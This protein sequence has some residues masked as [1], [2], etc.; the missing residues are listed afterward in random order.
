MIDDVFGP[1][2]ILS[3]QFEGYAPRKGQVDM[4]RAVAAGITGRRHVIAEGPTGTGKSLAYLVPAIDWATRPRENEPSRHEPRRVIVVTGN[5]AL[6]EQLVTKDLPLLQGLLP[7][8]FNFT[9][10]KG[11][12]N[13]L[14]HD[15][16]N[17]YLAGNAAARHEPQMERLLA[18]A[19]ET[20]TGDVSEFPETPAPMLWKQLSVS[21]DQCKGSSCKYHEQCFAEVAKRSMVS[22]NVVVT[23]YHLFFAH[24]LVRAK[25]RELQ[26]KGAPVNLDIVLPPAGVV[27]FDEAHKAADIAR[28]FLGFQISKGSIEWLV[29]GFRHELA[30]EIRR[31]SDAFFADLLEHK[32]SKLYKSR[33]KAGQPVQGQ[34]LA[35]LLLRVGDVYKHHANAAAW[36]QDERAELEMRA[37]R[38]Y[39]LS[40]QILTAMAPEKN[41]QAVYFIEESFGGTGSKGPGNLTKS[42]CVLK[43]KP[44]E[45][46]DWLE[47]ELFN[48]YPT[49]VVTSA[50]LSTGNG[51]GSFEFVKKDIG[52]KQADEI[53]AE[54]PFK[55][56]DQV[57]F[58]VPST[59]VDAK[60]YMNFAGAAANHV[61]DVARASRG[62]MLGLF[63]SYKGMDAAAQ[64][65]RGLP[66]KVLTQK[67]GPRTQLVQKFKADVSSC[68]LGCESFWAGVD[69][70]GESLSCVVIDRLPFPTPDDPIVDAIAE[71]DS[72]WFFNY[73]IP[74]AI[75]QLKQGFGRLIRTTSD[76]GV[77]VCLDRRI[78]ESSYGRSFIAALP[79]G[80]GFSK[81]M[82][83]IDRFFSAASSPA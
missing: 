39:T 21:S 76:R 62:R 15:A 37:R 79:R 2:G 33:L 19:Q 55:W 17:K 83:S 81:K 51:S 77:V 65:C 14:C 70:P 80:I 48:E 45:V 72:K 28:D 52:L 4:A 16:V 34:A 44:I 22:A 78:T 67:D 66:F 47:R 13:Y 20:K 36:S 42:S 75:I 50:T 32:R 49:V 58:V 35:D 46:N 60:D 31:A 68:L 24:L 25:M 11:R 59:M 57:L 71:K 12:N 63:T 26:A 8:A 61:A 82:E 43:S 64:A 38:S 54:S 10:Q 3:K 69:V 73:A 7:R 18:W 1:E 53:I 27:V 40:D 23:N 41:P 9:L 74:R 6:Q 30:D 5:I 29:R 56:R